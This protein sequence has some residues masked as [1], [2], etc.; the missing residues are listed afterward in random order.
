MASS[1][2]LLLSSFVVAFLTVLL[3]L[4][5]MQGQKNLL[6][7]SDTVL[8]KAFFKSDHTTCC[9]KFSDLVVFSRVLIVLVSR[10]G[11]MAMLFSSIML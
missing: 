1:R 3:L 4:T 7:E 11:A 2:L 9:G 10:N 5:S 6:E 8:D